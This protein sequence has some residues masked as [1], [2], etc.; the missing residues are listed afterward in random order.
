MIAFA[1]HCS[2][3]HKISASM[4]CTN[5]AVTDSSVVHLRGEEALT[6]FAQD[7]TIRSGSTMANHFCS[8][9]GTLMYRRSTGFEGITILRA[10]TVDDFELMEGVLKPSVEQFTEDRARWLKPVEGVRQAV[11][12]GF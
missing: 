7:D 12:P 1:C 10:G 9:C 3:C 8:K 2:D 5:F 11:G 6:R 4:F